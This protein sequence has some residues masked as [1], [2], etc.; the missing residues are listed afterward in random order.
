MVLTVDLAGAAVAVLLFPA[1]LLTTLVLAADEPLDRVLL[2]EDVRSLREP[3]DV[4][5]PPLL[6]VLPA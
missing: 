2:F 5:R 1:V 4:P 3:D 6:L